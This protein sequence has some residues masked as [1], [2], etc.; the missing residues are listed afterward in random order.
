[1][2]WEAYVE[3]V[4]AYIPL[5]S[6]RLSVATTFPKGTPAI[7]AALGEDLT[8][9]ILGLPYYHRGE[10]TCKW[11]SATH[12]IRRCLYQFAQPSM[13]LRLVDIGDLWVSDPS[14]ASVSDGLEELVQALLAKG[15][16]VICIG[17]GQ[18]AAHPLYRALA[19]Q[20][21]PFLYALI[22]ERL[23]L[24]DTLT[25]EELPHRQYHSDMLLDERV[26][27]S[28]WGALIG[29]AWH[30][31]SLEE[32]NLL[33]QKLQYP[34]L[35]LHEVLEE[36]NW[37]EPL[38]RMASLISVDLAVLRGADAP[39]VLDVSPEGLP[40]EVAAKLMR[41]A[42]MGY[43]SEVLHIANYFPKR[44]L[45]NRTAWAA[46]LL[47]WYFLEGQVNKPIDFP[48]P[49]RSNLYRQV[50]PLRGEEVP[51]L[52]FYQHP[53]TGRWWI[54][55]TPLGRPG[56]ARLFPCT[57]RDYQTALSGDI[58]RLWYLLRLVFPAF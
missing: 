39:A 57:E 32:E 36:P 13:A 22:D 18:E 51:E 56:P 3:P 24:V 14:P 1:M 45:D 15:H 9:V 19:A 58:P 4:Q 52:V 43:R 46:A 47:V 44:D 40:I 8:A 26:G 16:T 37:A 35:R 11:R 55:V 34:Y 27:V 6:S 7:E 54:Q 48:M 38:L 42:G 2:N 25:G 41:F 20:E 12:R 49:D 33:H 5:R 28:T 29:L 10:V 53:A 17:G 21:R 30:W 50:V 31:M 23:D